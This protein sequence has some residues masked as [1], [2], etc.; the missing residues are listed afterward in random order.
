MRAERAR[1]HHVVT[2]ADDGNE[3]DDDDDDDDKRDEHEQHRIKNRRAL[4]ISRSLMSGGQPKTSD[5]MRARAHFEASP[6]RIPPTRA[7]M[8]S[9][10]QFQRQ[11]VVLIFVT[12][13]VVSLL[14]LAA[15][16]RIFQ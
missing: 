7:R 10:Q 13:S 9:W 3:D 11:F 6:A 8:L 12:F 15:Y 1:A 16:L 4:Q 2:N 14:H 5:M